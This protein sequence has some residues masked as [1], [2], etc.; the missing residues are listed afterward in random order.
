MTARKGLVG[1]ISVLLPLGASAATLS[2]KSYSDVGAAFVQPSVIDS[3]NGTLNTTISMEVVTYAVCPLCCFMVGL[4]CLLTMAVAYYQAHNQLH[5]PNISNL[6]FH[7]GYVSS[8]SPGDDISISV[9]SGESF[10]YVVPFP[11]DH[12]PGTLWIHPHHH[13]STLL[14]V[15]GGAA[16]ALI[17]KDPSGFLPSQVENAT[18]YVWLIQEFRDLSGPA[19]DMGDTAISQTAGSSS[20]GTDFWLVNGLYRPVVTIAPG[21]WQRWRLIYAGYSDTKV[22]FALSDCEVQLLAKD[23]IYISDYPR[24]ISETGSIPVAERTSW[25]AAPRLALTPR[26]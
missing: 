20:D 19:S 23:G 21:E 3:V 10:Q 9:A 5:S 4:A 8:A 14:H 24:E 26:R 7:G 18:D 11:S 2:D 12:L 6:H 22:V 13:G 25:C 15:A 1:I 16:M 17:V